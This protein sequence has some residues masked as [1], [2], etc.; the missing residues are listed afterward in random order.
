MNAF[1]ER[2]RSIAYQFARFAGIGFLNTGVDFV[3]TNLLIAATGIT[4]G[5]GLSG[6]VSISFA[7]AVSHSFVWNKY[8]AF[9][10]TS[11]GL[12]KFVTKLLAAGATGLAAVL[13]A[14]SGANAGASW[15]FYAVLGLAF[16]VAEVVLWK[17]FRLTTDGVQ[18]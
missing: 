8:W 17:S 6:L 4:R 14:V 15:L 3:I 7:I 5:W 1:I 11:E 16:F 2:Y 12:P 18:A 10:S 9:A 13:I